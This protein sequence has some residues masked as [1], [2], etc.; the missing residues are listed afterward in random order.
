MNDE[1]FDLLTAH[2][3][4]IG[5]F[6]FADDTFPLDEVAFTDKNGQQWALFY[7]H[8]A[9]AE[10]IFTVYRQADGETSS[11]DEPDFEGNDLSALLDEHFPV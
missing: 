6:T 9:D 10:S 1:L 4:T 5:A 11:D 2:G 3:L 7:D 8:S